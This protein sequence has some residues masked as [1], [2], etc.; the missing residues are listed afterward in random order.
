MDL[1]RVS[2]F[3]ATHHGLLTLT[4]FLALGGSRSSWF[5]AIAASQF[6]R[7]HPCVVRMPGSPQTR[8]QRILAAVWGA[9]PGAV[10]SH[11]SAAY[12]WGVD[13]PEDDPI[14]IIVPQRSGRIDLGP[15]VVIH[16][17][18]DLREL[19]PVIRRGIP[20][21]NPFRM[22]SDLGAVDAA[23]VAV[24]LD[25]VFTEKL[26]SHEG[27]RNGMFRHAKRGHHGIGALRAALAEWEIDGKPSDGKLE[28]KMSETLRAFRLPPAE[29]HAIVAGYEV[30]FLITGTR[31]VLECD[32]YASHGMNRDQ[33]EFDR[34]RN[35]KI[36]AAGYVIVPFT[37]RQLTRAPEQVVTRIEEN[38]REWAPDVLAQHRSVRPRANRGV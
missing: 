5:R 29:F 1:R 3:A 2:A 27:V 38:L 33:F 23:G 25:H 13:R 26:A 20:C 28:K 37:W 35:P 15:D 11:R 34:L 14:D 32:G 36:T 10:A 30:D 7:V 22:L 9:G 12:L 4:A 19:R 21:V 31:I 17:P 18:R 6:E 24:A 16:R 8:E